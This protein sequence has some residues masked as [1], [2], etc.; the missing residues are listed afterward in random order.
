MSDYF[1]SVLLHVDKNSA[2]FYLRI[3]TYFHLA[4][5]DNSISQ[6]LNNK[7]KRWWF[8]IKKSHDFD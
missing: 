3:I 7:E 5:L 1:K 4:L 6:S 8:F 2:T